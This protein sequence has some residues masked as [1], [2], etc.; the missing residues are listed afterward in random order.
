M[1]KRILAKLLGN[2]E[3]EAP[4]SAPAESKGIGRPKSKQ[5]YEGKPT[6]P[7]PFAA[8]ADKAD[9]LKALQ[10]NVVCSYQPKMDNQRIYKPGRRLPGGDLETSFEGI[11]ASC[12]AL[13]HFGRKVAQQHGYSQPYRYV[14][15]NHIYRCCCG[16]PEDCPFYHL[17]QSERRS[18]DE[19]RF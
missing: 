3:P 4:Q 6:D 1:I 19:K 7:P 18:V 17:A 16:N 13:K 14:D 11:A 8:N 15:L 2:S 12:A 5:V 10:Q 9:L